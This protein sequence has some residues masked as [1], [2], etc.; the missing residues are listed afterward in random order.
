MAFKLK[1]ISCSDTVITAFAEVDQVKQNY[2]S[3]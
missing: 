2:L 3:A 1:G